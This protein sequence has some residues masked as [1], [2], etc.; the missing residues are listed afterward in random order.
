MIPAVQQSDGD[1]FYTGSVSGRL[2]IWNID[3]KRLELRVEGVQS[4][5]HGGKVT[6]IA[7]S[8]PTE[9]ISGTATGGF[10]RTTVADCMC[11][12]SVCN[13]HEQLGVFGYLRSA[14]YKIG[15]HITY[16]KTRVVGSRLAA[17]I[18]HGDTTNSLWVYRM[19]NDKDVH[20]KRTDV[21]DLSVGIG[22]GK[23]RYISCHIKAASTN[24][25]FVCVAS[26]NN[27]T[28]VAIT[29]S[30]HMMFVA[31]N[32]GAS[33]SVSRPPE[34]DAGRY[35]GISCNGVYVIVW[36]ST[37]T[38]WGVKLTG[39]SASTCNWI[40]CMEEVSRAIAFEGGFFVTN[41]Y[42]ESACSLSDCHLKSI[43]G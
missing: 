11:F 39:V 14:D 17:A 43:L 21:S 3:S 34:N 22:G 36:T 41:C 7:P 19:E 40:K 33:C 1:R 10:K 4:Q 15:P 25:P 5:L 32:A 23:V 28:A 13:L 9:L 37:G 27:D 12:P 18:V 26:D 38:C 35:V 24:G 42:S 20:T 31:V 2:V 16:I 8:S 30:G 6:W 29:S